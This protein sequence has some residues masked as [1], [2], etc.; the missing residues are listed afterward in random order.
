[1]QKKS[2][3]KSIQHTRIKISK[4]AEASNVNKYP[5]FYTLNYIWKLI[6]NLELSVFCQKQHYPHSLLHLKLQTSYNCK[7]V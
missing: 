1:M 2:N 3:P 5:G 6:L 7:N 4:Q